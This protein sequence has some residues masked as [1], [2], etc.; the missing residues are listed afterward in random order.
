[1]ESV[2]PARFLWPFFIRVSC[3][4]PMITGGIRN[5]ARHWRFRAQAS[6]NKHFPL[7]EVSTFNKG[8]VP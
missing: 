7:S 3:K 6:I 4:S 1:M 8:V 5:D 2:R